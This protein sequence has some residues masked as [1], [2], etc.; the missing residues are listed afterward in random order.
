MTKDGWVNSL[1]D[2]ID[3]P[4]PLDWNKAIDDRALAAW[5]SSH[6]DMF[7]VR[8]IFDC[9]ICKDPR[10]LE[11]MSGSSVCQARTKMIHYNV[12]NIT[13]NR[14]TDF[15]QNPSEPLCWTIEKAKRVL[16]NVQ[17]N[18]GKEFE[19]RIHPDCHPTDPNN[20]CSDCGIK[21]PHCS[22]TMCVA[23]KAIMSMGE[24]NAL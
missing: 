6:N 23:C 24:D 1:N 10:C 22:D 16:D 3:I 7:E 20:K 4:I 15:G 21:M 2:L 9:P 11:H 18:G 5:Q 8:A 14:W 19:I 17:Y 12:W 13:E